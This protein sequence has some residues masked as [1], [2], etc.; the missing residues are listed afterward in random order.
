MIYSCYY[1]R[2][3]YFL[4]ACASFVSIVVLNQLFVHRYAV[5][6]IFVSRLVITVGSFRQLIQPVSSRS[7]SSTVFKMANRFT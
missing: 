5:L 7:F 1:A 2:M 4:Q 3:D 6:I